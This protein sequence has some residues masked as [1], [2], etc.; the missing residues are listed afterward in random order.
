MQL[1]RKIL[2]PVS[3]IYALVVYVRN[4]F[5]DRGWLSSKKFTTPTICIGNLSVGGT[6]K[7]PMAEFIIKRLREQYKV[8]LLSRGYKRKSSGFLLANENTSVEEMG[9]EP[10]QIYSKFRNISVAV[11]ADRQ[12]GIAKLQS[13]ISPEVILL[14]DAFQ[15]RK[16]SC[17]SYI[18]L[19]PYDNLYVNDWY[20]PTGDL[21]DARN[22]AQR[23]QVIVVTKC[24]KNLSLEKRKAIRG[25][26]KPKANQIVLFCYFEYGTM[27]LGKNEISLQEINFKDITLVTGIANPKPLVSYLKGRGL[28]FEH[29][30]F[31]DHHYFSGDE[32][33]ELNSK[34]FVLT[35]EKDY[36][37][38]KDKVANLWYISV[39]HKFY[40]EDEGVLLNEI[41]AV[42]QQNS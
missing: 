13:L 42:I 27:L 16:V 39:E 37:R 30:C 41:T 4:Y 40:E 29:L 19:T 14:D 9:D 8:A 17:H 18:L 15:H 38:L 31:A 23:A 7:T 22:Q 2:F 10:F 11:D 1:L 20:L 6:G 5:Y 34:E 36:V 25:K 21:R 35:T 3:L 24:P 12:N 33:R 32:I 28:T 26:L